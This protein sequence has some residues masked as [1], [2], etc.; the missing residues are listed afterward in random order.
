[1]ESPDFA[2]RYLKVATQLP[3]HVDHRTRDIEVEL[4]TGTRKRDPLRHRLDFIHGLGGFNLDDAQNF[5]AF[6]GRLQNQVWKPGRLPYRDRRL[7]FIPEV[8]GNLELSLIFR[9]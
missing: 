9:L 5:P 8:H 2:N 6:V 1:M 7:L 4:R 3:R